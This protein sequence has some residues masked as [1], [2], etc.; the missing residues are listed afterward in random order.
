M[1]SSEIESLRW[2]TEEQVRNFAAETPLPAFLY[3]EEELRNQ[4]KK[5]WAFP[6]N[7]GYGFQLRF[8]MKANPNKTVLHIMRELGVEIDAGSEYEVLRAIRSGYRP[9]QI[10]LTAQQMATNFESLI[11]QGVQ[12][13]ACSLRQMEEFGKRR[14]GGSLG[15]RFNPGLG[16]G[17]CAKTDV[18]GSQSAFGIWHEKMDLVKDMASRYQLKINTVHTHIGSGS[19]PEIWK[20]V[21]SLTLAIASQ[22]PDCT[23]VNL[24]GGY[25]VGRMMDEISTDLQQIGAPVK[26]LFAQFFEEHGRKLKLEIE[27][28][29]FYTVNMGIIVAYVDDVID[30]GANGHHFVKLNVGMDS[31]TRPSLYG[32]RHPITIVPHTSRPS[33]Q[34][35]TY[36]VAGHCCESGDLFT[37]HPGGAIQPRLL[38]PTQIGDFAVIGGAG[39]YCARMSTKNYNTDPEIAEYMMNLDGTIRVIRKVQTLDQ[40]L[41]NE[42]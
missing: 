28:G 10:Q 30:T 11:D 16:S 27:P 22:F 41:E 26:D 34:P 6:V 4:I 24:G 25:K 23:T 12:F 15:L 5:A 20:H 39:A 19:D 42:I 32:A 18:A 13:T 7:D 3:S 2:I 35:I 29:S 8:A 14:F 1:A 17:G 37:Q 9:D 21:A 36:I 38:A 33:A 40:I 31:I